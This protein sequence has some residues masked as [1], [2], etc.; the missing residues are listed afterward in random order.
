MKTASLLK[1]SRLVANLKF[2]ILTF[3]RVNIGKLFW[4][5]LKEVI[6]SKFSGFCPCGKSPLFACVRNCLSPMVFCD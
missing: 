2:V 3:A 6:K 1:L 4:M 5:A